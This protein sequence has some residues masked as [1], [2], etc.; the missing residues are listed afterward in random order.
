[1]TLLSGINAAG[2]SS[3]MQALVLLHQTMRDHEWSD[4]LMLN[5]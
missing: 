2:K 4:K 3:V 1:M 5:G